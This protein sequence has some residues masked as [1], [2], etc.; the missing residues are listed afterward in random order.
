MYILT[1]LWYNYSA[2]ISACFFLGLGLFAC[3]WITGMISHVF[4][5]TPEATGNIFILLV[6]LTVLSCLLALV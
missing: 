5:L 4:K 2:M 6:F 1:F 3:L